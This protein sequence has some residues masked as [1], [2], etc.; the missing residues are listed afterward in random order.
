MLSILF[1]SGCFVVNC[2]YLWPV[3]CTKSSWAVNV[4]ILVGGEHLS[5][6]LSMFW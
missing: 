3:A 2:S 1:Y 6:L 5:V 4:S